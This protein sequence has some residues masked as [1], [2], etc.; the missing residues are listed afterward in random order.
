MPSHSHV[1]IYVFGDEWC[2]VGGAGCLNK[3]YTVRGQQVESVQSCNQKL[4]PQ[5][6]TYGSK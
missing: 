5:R 4:E 6:K 1:A 2:T 3:P